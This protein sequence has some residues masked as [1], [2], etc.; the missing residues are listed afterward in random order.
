MGKY[1]PT[2]DAIIEAAENLILEGLAYPEDY[3]A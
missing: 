1:R 2:N 3:D